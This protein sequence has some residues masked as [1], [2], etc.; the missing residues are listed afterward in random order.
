MAA[1]VHCDMLG[2]AGRP[3]HDKD[4]R[5]QTCS[6]RISG[7]A[8]RPRVAALFD[9]P[10]FPVDQKSEISEPTKRRRSQVTDNYRWSIC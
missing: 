8:G 9:T 10:S 5:E 6:K 1:P 2:Y 3:T 4:L 7:W